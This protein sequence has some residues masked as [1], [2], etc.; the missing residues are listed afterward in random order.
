[1][2]QESVDSERVEHVMR[3]RNLIIAVVL[4]SA[5]GI[6]FEWKTYIFCDN[7]GNAER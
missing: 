7:K 6:F 4:S 3:N 1:L 5:I 2:E